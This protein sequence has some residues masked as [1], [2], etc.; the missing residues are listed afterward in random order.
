MYKN[1]FEH[2]PRD[3]DGGRQIASR[4]DVLPIGLLFCD[5][6][7]PIYEEYSTQGMDMTAEEKVTALNKEL[8]RFAI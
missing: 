7:R 8:D 4:D 1:R 2:D 3:L 5:P 6:D